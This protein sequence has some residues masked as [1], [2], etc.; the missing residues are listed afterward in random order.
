MKLKWISYKNTLLG[1]ISVSTKHLY[2]ISMDY[3]TLMFISGTGLGF[4]WLDLHEDGGADIDVVEEHQKYFLCDR[5]GAN[6][7]MTLQII[8]SEHGLWRSND[9]LSF[10]L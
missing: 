10:E 1:A 7:S 9:T 6:G 8:C 2:P 4:H 5:F 3:K